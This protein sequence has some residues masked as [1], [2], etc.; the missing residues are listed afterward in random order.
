VPAILGTRALSSQ[1]DRILTIFM[2]PLMSCSARLP[3][4]AL[5][6]LVFFEAQAGIA[7]F[8]LYLLGIVVAILTGLL[9][10]KTL[11][12]GEKSTFIMELPPYHLPRIAT[13]LK[14]TWHRLKDFLFKAGKFIVIAM[15][16][17]GL[18]NSFNSQLKPAT[19]SGDTLLAHIG[20][21]ITP[22]FSPFG[23]KQDNWQASVALLTGILAKEAIITILAS[24][25]NFDAHSDNYDKL[26]TPSLMQTT[27]KAFASIPVNLKAAFTLSNGLVSSDSGETSDSESSLKGNMQNAFSGGK[28]QAFAYLIFVLLYMPC[29]AATGTAFNELGRFYWAILIIY[30]SLTAWTLATL[31]YQ[32]VVGHSMLWIAISLVIIVLMIIVLNIV[33]TK[34]AHKLNLLLNLKPK[35]NKPPKCSC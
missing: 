13:L 15:L 4:F 34:T 22:I 1:R 10:N 18:L 9:F 27:L 35:N 30:L 32:I 8:F 3:V 2:A 6:T 20:R 5:F 21:A 23:V 28:W 12:K 7:L 33:G 16:V 24:L 29:L 31:F 14:H 19:H 25:Y 11:V 17:L 26:P